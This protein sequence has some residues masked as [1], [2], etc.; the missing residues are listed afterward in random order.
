MLLGVLVALFVVTRVPYL[1]GLVCF[2]VLLVG[3]G[4]LVLA[5]VARHRAAGAPA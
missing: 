4:S 5:A 2:V 1:G 3:M